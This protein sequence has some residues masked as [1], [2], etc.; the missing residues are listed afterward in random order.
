MPSIE[1][2]RKQAKLLVRW[3]REGNYSVGGKV[4]LI[5]RYRDLTDRAI[6]DAP[7]PLTLAQE[8]VAVEAG[9]A[10]WSSLLRHVEEAEL[11]PPLAAAD[12]PTLRSAVPILFVRDV[13]ASA[14]YYE[15]CLGFTVDFLH[16]EPAFYAALSRGGATLHLRHV[17]S[18]NFAELAA[19]DLR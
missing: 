3:H 16:G 6:L 1:T 12:Q 14:N 18:P 4:R 19:R 8:I 11:P 17:G 7:L 13:A 10:D 15:R 9:F 2:F 5:E